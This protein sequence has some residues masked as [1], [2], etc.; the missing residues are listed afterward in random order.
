MRK[1]K[2]RILLIIIGLLICITI[3]AFTAIEVNFNQNSKLN[4]NVKNSENDQLIEKLE[5]DYFEDLYSEVPDE[6]EDKNKEDLESD[7]INENENII[8]TASDFLEDNF[9]YNTYTNNN[10]NN[11]RENENENQN[12]NVNSNENTNNTESNTDLYAVGKEATNFEEKQKIN[13]NIDQTI[14]LP[15]ID[16]ETGVKYVTYEDF[17]AK[18]DE[19]YDNYESFK[20]THDYANKY[21]YEVRAMQDSYHI[22]KLEELQPIL[23]QTS[24]DWGKAEIFIHDE[25]IKNLET[26]KY[27]IFYINYNEAIVTINDKE[28]LE[29]IQLNRQTTNIPELQGYGNRLC[30]AYNE[31]KRQF[32]RDGADANDGNVQQDVFRIDNNGNILN[33]IQWDFDE[34]TSIKMLPIPEETITIK[35]ANFITVLSEDGLEYENEYFQRNIRCYRSNVIIDNI[36]HSV[37]NKDIVGG[38]YYGFIR[39]STACEVKITNCELYSHKYKSYSTYD[40]LLE[41]NTNVLIK[42]VVSNDIYDNN[43]WGITGMNYTKDITYENCVLNRI[44]AHCGVHNLNIYNCEVGIKGI[45]LV[46]SG[47]LNIK[48]TSAVSDMGFI[49]LRSDYGSTWNG[50]I[51]IENC[52]YNPTMA[53]TIVAFGIYYEQNTDVHDFG[54]DLCLPNININGIKINEI[55]NSKRKNE[56]YVYYCEEYINDVNNE[57]LIA[58]YNLPD[59]AYIYNCNMSLLRTIKVFYT[60]KNLATEIIIDNSDNYKLDNNVITNINAGMTIE[61]LK[62]D[63]NLGIKYEVLRQGKIL[64][65]NELIATSDTVICENEEL[66][67]LIVK[68]DLNSDGLV[69]LIDLVKMKRYIVGFEKLEQEYIKAADINLDEGDINLIDL[70]A[71]KNIIAE[72]I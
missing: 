50:N 10:S 39:I 24:T 34:I 70:I 54:Y 30:I 53:E 9:E 71:I 33:D 48:N 15:H 62:R 22:Y 5:A 46:G 12:T 55:D 27:S 13:K 47:E 52:T 18:S 72:I 19:D 60:E 44:D 38:A 63:L 1:N 23:I 17:G 56:L 2:K 7:N 28:I 37:S 45:I 11:Y 31:N 8:E 36:N 20:L 6:G 69:N 65:E 57:K 43:R 67:L 59:K 42:G 64:Q 32:V 25:D 3:L 4:S 40:L 35:N 16:E 21:G 58:T 26:K 41:Y 66:Y 51:N 14:V 29:Q 61:Q 68:G 49:I